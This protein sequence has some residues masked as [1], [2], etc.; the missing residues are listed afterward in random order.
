MAV[1]QDIVDAS[2]LEQR[3]ERPEAG[4]LVEDFRYEVVEFLRVER[5]PLGQDVLRHQLLDMLADFVLWQLFQ[6]GKIDLLN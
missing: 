2:V 4:H 1:D 6:R 3:L 5:Q